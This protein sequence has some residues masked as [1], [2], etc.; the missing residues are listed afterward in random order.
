LSAQMA[1]TVGLQVYQWG[2]A[3]FL[4]TSNPL[5]HFNTN[6]KTLVYKEKG[7]ALIRFN[8]SVDREN[9]V[10]AIVEPVSNNQPEWIEGDAFTPKFLIKYERSWRE[11]A[12]YVGVVIGQEEKHNPF[13]GEYFNYGFAEGFSV[14]GDAKQAQN[15]INYVPAASGSFYNMTE[16]ADSKNK[17]PT[18]SVLGLR[19]EDSFDLRAEY[20][21]NGMGYDKAQLKSA[22]ASA[23]GFLNPAYSQNLK[24]FLKPGLE[25]LGKNYIYLSY[26][27]T[28]PFNSKELN[29]Y[30]RYLR[31]LQD[32]SAQA[33][34]EFEK[35]LSDQWLVF[36]NL[37]V[38]E[39]HS[40]AEFRLL[41]DWQLLVGLKLGL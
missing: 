38:A 39:G 29:F 41:N 33:Q 12:D 13:V 27:I 2:P 10:V 21:Y 35:S 4:N 32:E 26:R 34:A 17:W 23:A 1:A 14:Y 28:E 22:I 24:N 36:S 25:I 6:Q 8:Y 19:F 11:T 37:S 15:F 9:S 5:Y 30:L 31:S 20:V 7:Q 16:V 3:E 40:D 18:L